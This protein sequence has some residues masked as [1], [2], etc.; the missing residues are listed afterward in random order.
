VVRPV[1][2]F[3][4][5]PENFGEAGVTNTELEN[6][7]P[8]AM[9]DGGESKSNVPRWYNRAPELAPDGAGGII[10]STLAGYGVLTNIARGWWTDSADGTK[11]MRTLLQAKEEHGG[12]GP[13][14]SD[15]TILYLS[16]AM[17]FIGAAGRI[18]LVVL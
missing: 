16:C 4:P 14:V 10:D 6:Y 17:G 13:S 11:S 18:A 2:T 5:G 12:E 9:T 15:K 1:L 3:E 7:Q 8:D